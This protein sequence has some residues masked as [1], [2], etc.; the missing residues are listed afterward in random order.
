MTSTTANTDSASESNTRPCAVRAPA[1][2]RSWLE[3]I[4]D[5]QHTAQIVGESALQLALGLQ[6]THYRI[7]SSI[8]RAALLAL[9]PRAVPTGVRSG[10]ITI[11]TKAGALEVMPDQAPSSFYQ[12]DQARPFRILA[13]AVDPFIE[14]VTASADTLA[15]M[16]QRRLVP[17]HEAQSGLTVQAALEAARLIAL[18][19]FHPTE[20][21]LARALQEPTAPRPP[22][23]RPRMRYALRE[24]LL[25]SN[26]EPALT[27]LRESGSEAALVTGVRPNAAA[28]VARL[29]ADAHLRICAWMIDAEARSLMRTLRFGSEF[30]SE[31][32]RTLELH[33]ID[34]C[35]NPNNESA[36]RKLLGRV[37]ADDL[38]NL[39]T[40]R[41]AEAEV[42]GFAG[43]RAGAEQAKRG[44][45]RIEEAFATARAKA[46]EQQRRTQ[47]AISGAQ[48]M[49]TLS[50]PPGPMI[51]R[52]MRFLE[53]KV[54]AQ[55]EINTLDALRAEL[56]TWRDAS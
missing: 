49:Q 7:H 52:A 12:D 24:V 20:E 13:L 23:E 44:I 31:I 6:P 54:A 34:A 26:V 53:H 28:L 48:I 18:Y 37:P 11:P 27:W 50:C 39:L 36:V 33:P 51:G 43:D 9:A 47:L 40:L 4:A 38:A 56:D 2:I 1:P 25:A 17:T 45:E 30:A 14:E 5:A 15:D 10:C 21:L 32:Y 35:V 16:D 8:D 22:F 55:P 19:D 41:R 46:S 3:R 29:P 42:L